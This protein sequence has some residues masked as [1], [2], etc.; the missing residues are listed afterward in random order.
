MNNRLVSF[1]FPHDI[2]LSVLNEVSTK[3]SKQQSYLQNREV[4]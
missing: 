3:V 1:I 2:H 4:A